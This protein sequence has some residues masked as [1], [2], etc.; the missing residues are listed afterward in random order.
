MLTFRSLRQLQADASGGVLLLFGLALPVL[1]GFGAAA[2]EYGSLI[3][4][5]VELQNAADAAAL[6]AAGELAL[7]AT[8]DTRIASVAK[9]VVARASAV[10]AKVGVAV[11]NNRT[12]VQVTVDETVKS[13]IGRI[14][15][16]PLDSIRVQATAQH[17]SGKSKLCMMALDTSKPDVLHLH[18]HAMITAD[19]CTVQSNS[20]DPNGLHVEDNASVSAD[21]VCSSGG[22]R[23]GKNVNWKRAPVTDCPVIKDP[24]AARMPPPLPSCLNLD[25]KI[26]GKIMP[27]TVLPPG[28]YCGGL[29]ITNGAKVTL[30]PGTYVVDNGPLVVD[31]GASLSG[32]YVGFYFTGDKG[33]LLFDVESTISL[34]APK[35]GPM[36]GLLMFENRSVSAP[37]APP[38][39]VKLA[40]PPPPPPGSPPMRTYRIV[41]DN[42]RTLL[43]TIY[44]PAGRLIIDASKPVADLSAYTVIVARQVELFDGPN[45]VLNTNYGGTDVPVPSGVGPVE[46]VGKSALVQ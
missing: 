31:H 4:R 29:K 30:L 16:R 19:G 10:D 3:K 33:G 40:P 14:L 25:L 26:D 32:S 38:L 24:L 15:S 9:A 42:A 12:A 21:R 22:Y 39:G 7:A 43:G 23:G 46:G 1:L 2:L 6:V 13:V 41:S 34:S 8:T 17:V 37:V 44:L 20:S 18:K 45:L 28:V 5:R 36:A 11:I 27:P 35:D